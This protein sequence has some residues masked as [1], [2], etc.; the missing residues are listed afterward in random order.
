MCTYPI[1]WG[2]FARKSRDFKFNAS[3]RAI[4]GTWRKSNDCYIMVYIWTIKF[5]KK[6]YPHPPYI[7]YL[8]LKQI[9]KVTSPWD[10]L[11]TIYFLCRNSYLL[12]N[13]FMKKYF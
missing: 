2:D 7:L 1:N 11:A 4:Y 6:K 10:E 13:L 9:G 12:H 5:N 8:L 3:Y